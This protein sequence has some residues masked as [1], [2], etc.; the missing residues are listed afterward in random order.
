MT[1]QKLS[2]I[3]AWIGAVFWLVT[4][5]WAFVAPRSFFDNI[6]T[7]EPYNRHFLHDAGAFALGLGAVL[8]FA[9]VTQWDALRVA[10]AGV[11]LAAVM[12]VVAHAVDTDLG[13]KS[14]DIPGLVLLA[15]VIVYGAAARRADRQQ[16][17]ASG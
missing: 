14:T 12:H 17:S 5:V 8:I 6:A 4:G 1:P 13:G 2:R 7:F 15:I 16:A 9:L 11:G 10:L 3:A